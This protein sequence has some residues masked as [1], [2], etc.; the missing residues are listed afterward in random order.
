MNAEQFWERERQVENL[1]L[2]L[3]DVLE[4]V[5]PS[6]AR[7]AVLVLATAWFYRSPFRIVVRFRGTL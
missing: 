6:V 5:S 7:S 3:S 1:A 4:G 2:K